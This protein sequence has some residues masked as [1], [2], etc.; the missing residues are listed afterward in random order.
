[1]N[2]KQNYY[3][4]LLCNY[5]YNPLTIYMFRIYNLKA[6]LLR[7]LDTTILLFMDSALF[8]LAISCIL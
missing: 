2:F 7:K 4:Y 6:Y 5:C 8:L 1:M 3:F